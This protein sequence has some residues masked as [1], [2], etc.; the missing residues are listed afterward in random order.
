MSVFGHG[1]LL[2]GVSDRDGSSF[3]LTEGP[4]LRDKAGAAP[5]A[6]PR[7][8]DRQPEPLK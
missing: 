2:V 6:L 5:Q 1:K 4:R 8:P 3:F 7:M